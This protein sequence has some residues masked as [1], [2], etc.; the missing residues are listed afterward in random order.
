[1]NKIIMAISFLMAGVMSFF[2]PLSITQGQGS[3][4][5]ECVMKREDEIEFVY[6]DDI[7]QNKDENNLG[8]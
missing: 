7:N 3:C 5:A 4:C 8:R 1:M 2:S 6:E